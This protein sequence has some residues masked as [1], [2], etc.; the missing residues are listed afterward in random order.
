MY[1]NKFMWFLAKYLEAFTLFF[2][3]F[4]ITN[5]EKLTNQILVP[6]LYSKSIICDFDI[7]TF[8]SV[9]EIFPTAELQG[10]F[11]HLAKNMRKQ[12]C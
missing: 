2:T 7:A 12:L 1:S 8:K 10:C 6:N 4:C 11:Y 5:I 3:N 9:V